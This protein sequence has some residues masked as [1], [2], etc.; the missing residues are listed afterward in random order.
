MS[1]YRLMFFYSFV[2]FTVSTVCFEPRKRPQLTPT[3]WSQDIEVKPNSKDPTLKLNNHP[4]ARDISLLKTLWEEPLISFGS[5]LQS[6]SPLKSWTCYT[7]T[8][9]LD[10]PQHGSQDSENQTEMQNP[11]LSFF[12]RSETAGQ[13]HRWTQGSDPRWSHREVSPVGKLSQ[14]WRID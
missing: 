8:P 12:E 14:Q 9:P 2:S 11:S 6:I 1:N 5:W 13:Q 4:L 7:L 3:T 10:R